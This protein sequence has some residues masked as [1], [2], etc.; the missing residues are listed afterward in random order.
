MHASYAKDSEL[1]LRTINL[2]DSVFP[3]AKRMIMKGQEF[4]ANWQAASIPFLIERNNELIAHLSIVPIDIEINHVHYQTAALHAICVKP[5]FRG[6]GHFTSLMQ[7]ALEYI[8]TH[9]DSTCLF[10][11]TP[12]L[13]QP[14]GYHVVQQYDFVVKNTE[15]ITAKNGL[16]PLY[17][18]QPEDLRLFKRLLRE[19]IIHNPQFNVNH[20]TLYILNSLDMKFYYIEH[21]DAVI[22]YKGHH[23][24]YI[25]DIISRMPVALSEILKALPKNRH[26]YV[27]QFY[28]STCIDLPY[29]TI[30]S[31]NKGVFMACSRF[32][33]PEGKFRWSEM[34]RC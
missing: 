25:Q 29:Q 33:M 17:L 9:F 16:R 18:E 22:V 34:A 14:F 8:Q 1:F 23:T 5:K 10:T 12:T 31:K 15:M 21:L 19:R 27:L 6:Q 26:E 3:G 30:R 24:F 28:S 32:T 13:Y 11:E 2:I 4:G 20:E 7:E